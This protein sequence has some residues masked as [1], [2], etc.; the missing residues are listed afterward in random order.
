MKA[1]KSYGQHFLIRPDIAERIAKLMLP[2]TDIQQIVE[3]GPG[4]GALTQH[5]VSLDK[6][7]C[8]IE[9]D[10]NLLPILYN[11][12]GNH[13]LI[14]LIHADYLRFDLL[15]HIPKGQFGIIGNFPY[16]ISSQI[17][18]SLIRYHQRCPVMIGMFQK[19]LADRVIAPPGDK[20]YGA[21]SA[22]IQFYYIGK[23]EFTLGPGAFDPPPKVKSSVITLT[24]R[25]AYPDVPYAVYRQL[26]KQAFNMRRKKLRN[27]IGSLFAEEVVESDPIFQSRPER[28]SV[29]DFVT[30]VN[31]YMK[32]QKA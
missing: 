4:T 21:I 31:I 27:S 5:L 29:D 13:P 14:E 15:K 17:V 6:P 26:V 16:N 30:L 11:N 32:G 12:F 20:T 9:A 25:E 22:L 1:R 2:Y 18:M 19:E 24:R 23:H 28:L 3:V 8:A 10:K 7:I